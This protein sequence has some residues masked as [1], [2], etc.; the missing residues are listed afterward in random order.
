MRREWLAGTAPHGDGLMQPEALHVVT[1]QG[2]HVTGAA[3]F[4]VL[5]S[6]DASWPEA[7][8]L[9]RHLANIAPVCLIEVQDTSLFRTLEGL[10]AHV[11]AEMR[12][13]KTD[14]APYRFAGLGSAALLA[15]EVARQALMRDEP[16]GFVGALEL[17]GAVA[18][19]WSDWA[20]Q[21]QL[22][23]LPLTVHWFGTT[24]DAA[25]SLPQRMA[26]LAGSSLRQHLDSGQ[27]HAAADACGDELVRCVA[28]VPAA[29]R[30]TPAELAYSSLMTIQSPRQPAEP[31][32]CVPGAGASVFDFLPLAS[33]MG[34]QVAVHGL[35]S[36]GMDGNLLPFG[37]IE[38][39]VQVH[40]REIERVAPRQPLHLVGHSFGG[41]VAFELAL[42]L[43]AQG[44]IVRSL[45]LLDS[46][47]PGLSSR[48]GHEYSRVEALML[49][50]WL[51]EQASGQP[52]EL[53]AEQ[54]ETAGHAGQLQLLHRQLVKVGLMPARSVPEHLRGTL[55]SFEAAIRTRYQP[56]GTF[57]GVA[58]LVLVRGSNEFGDSATR[59]MQQAF[60]GWQNLAPGLELRIEKGNHV[61]LLKSPHIDS[62]AHWMKTDVPNPVPHSGPVHHGY[63]FAI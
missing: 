62:V 36:R 32:F 52:L 53:T 37:N 10:A 3:P 20:A 29:S 41:W 34:S 35:Q 1:T 12:S 26:G 42:R 14:G 33:A 63:R 11:M 48:V 4:F 40:L 57:N 22:E 28:E 9:L 55:R 59:R 43:Q 18:G 30:A 2:S 17:P 24:P 39:A 50:V 54:F 16:V 25:G 23:P 61:T 47:A 8:L 60:E 49:L 7:A 46:E 45:T 44:R 51:Y 58:R 21:Y 38:A 31:Y 5:R 13:W 56:V 6:N 19:V 27:G 15:Y